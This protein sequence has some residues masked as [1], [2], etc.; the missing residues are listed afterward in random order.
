M[1]LYVYMYLYPFLGAR[2][3]G[4][5]KVCITYTCIHL[6]MRIFANT[7]GLYRCA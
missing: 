1:Y 4:C 2:M 6:Y 3:L 7:N 5:I